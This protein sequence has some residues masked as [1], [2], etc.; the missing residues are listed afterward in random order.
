MT[1][2]HQVEAKFLPVSFAQ[3]RLWFLDQLVPG[4]S[5]YNEHTSVRL[6]FP[7]NVALLERS[8]AEI[9]NR[10][11]SLRTTFIVVDG[12][13]VQV[14]APT[15]TVPLSA[16]DL[17][18][19]PREE[20]EPDAIRL[21]S[22][23]ACK[24]F[25]LRIGPLI[26]TTLL[27]LDDCDYLFLLTMHHIVS[28]GWSLGV[29]GRELE[30]LYSAFELGQPS[31]LKPLPIQYGDFAVWQRRR[32]QGRTLDE[33]VSYW[34]QQ[35]ANVQALQLTTDY[36][37]PPIP[38]FHGAVHTAVYSPALLAALR[39][40]G[41]EEG[42]TLFMVLLAGFQLLLSRYTDQDDIVVG[43][44]IA[45]RNRVELEG[46]IGFFVNTLAMRTRLTGNPTVRELLARVRVMA[47]DA[48]AH[49]DLPFE[50]LVE[51][52]Q[53]RRDMARNPVFQVVL[54]LFNTP[55]AGAP[56]P[57]ATTSGGSVETAAAK[58]DVTVHLAERSDGLY[59]RFEY[60][61]DLF[62]PRTIERMADHFGRLLNSMAACPDEPALSLPF[63]APS[64]RQQ[65]LVDWNSTAS[66]YPRESSLQ[67]LFESQVARTPDALAVRYGATELTYRD[68]NR[69]A[70]GVARLLR[71]AGVG[72]DVL[73]AIAVERSADMVAAVLGVIKAGGAYVPIDPAYPP[74]RIALMMA[75]ARAPVLLTHSSLRQGLD[76]GGARV[77]CL[78]TDLGD[79]DAADSFDDNPAGGAT[80]ES[81]AYVMY[82][83]G[84]TGVPK[85]VAVPQ[86]A[87]A[88]LV[89]NTD[90]VS[91][92]ASDRLAQVSTFSF[93][94]ATFEIWGA[95]LTGASLVG[96]R[97][98]V[99]LAS[100]AF[101]QELR[102]ARI[103]TLFLTTSLFNHVASQVP[104]A[105]AT[106]RTLIVGGEA[107]D[108]KWA[109]L[110]LRSGA[111][112]RLL[113]AYGPTEGTT[114]T[115]CFELS[116]RALER[117]PVPIGRPISNTKLYVLDSRQ[118]LVPAGVPGE[119]YIAGD[120]L[121]RGYWNDAELSGRRFV[122]LRLAPDQIVR[123]YRTGDLVQW[124]HDGNLLFLGRLD[125]QV[126]LRGFRVEP[127]EI[128][129]ALLQHPGVKQAVVILRT[130]EQGDKRLVSYVL[131]PAATPELGDELRR[132]LKERLPDF[133]VPAAILC[134]DTMPLGPSGKIDRS[135][136]PAPDVPW[137]GR[138]TT[139]PGSDLERTIAG[140]WRET[141][142]VEHVGAN[143]NFFDLGGH[144]L[145]LAKVHNRL[146][147]VLPHPVS[148]I[149]L[150]R[151]PSIRSLASH[152]ESSVHEDTL[153]A[154][155]HA[156]VEKQRG[157]Q[158]QR[159]RHQPMEGGE[160]R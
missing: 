117:L 139:P 32:L 91:L 148:F 76:A 12:Q 147:A 26:R 141:L 56:V 81:L 47:L 109:S 106:L 59:A 111:P 156:R 153:L 65:L 15:G 135:A 112:G 20:R 102:Q 137:P 6:K 145:L 120:G 14:I 101:A 158:R 11:E 85:G 136:L 23:E 130:S 118:Q 13:P 144:S 48:Y 140:I 69:R 72:P 62:E 75:D 155:V 114:F 133:M 61:T 95:L 97:H 77:V 107:M 125:N 64:E 123:C 79:C 27:Q 5:F 28:D 68:L 30:A 93:D 66:S 138:D 127:G 92:E 17:R 131:A 159:P 37:R 42:A 19:L 152:L 7:V 58:F 104:E 126:K 146:E 99:A 105:F 67:Q 8:L 63:L 90:Y 80:S 9:V 98:D 50:K 51:E 46:L 52:L 24:P 100:N 129:A 31:P 55:G 151:Y 78:D 18:H 94:A 86:R 84:S 22:A 33:H 74:P 49:Q 70:N 21:A 124:R 89:L 115:T 71:E 29:F 108:P 10:H 128:E 43:V 1:H 2:A 150:F 116:P 53:P 60:A 157:R 40:L 121:A 149:D 44:P 88:R 57:P 41:Q 16:I 35:L 113:N 87:V 119:L 82:T 38:S 122:T 96:I 4:S 45:N 73:V 3:Q 110:V 154:E 132:T 25:D 160:A 134:R 142:G 36:P 83:S 39:R 54:Q 143:D 103:T 34:K